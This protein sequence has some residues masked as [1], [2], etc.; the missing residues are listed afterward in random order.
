MPILIYINT[1]VV[2]IDPNT[3]APKYIVLS[4]QYIYYYSTKS[5]NPRSSTSKSNTS[6]SVT[7]KKDRPRYRIAEILSS[8]TKN[9]PTLR[10]YPKIENKP[11]YEG[12]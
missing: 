4:P 12:S 5:R 9:V 2:S 3:T 6:M 1:N 11:H 7:P 10:K 8:L